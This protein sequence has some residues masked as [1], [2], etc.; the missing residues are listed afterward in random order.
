MF[1]ITYNCEPTLTDHQVIEFCQKGFIILEGVVADE[2]NRR[3]TNFLNDYPQLEPV[4]I[5]QEDWFV[6]SVIKNPQ[7]TGAVGSLL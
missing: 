4:E 6:E 3:T 5:L 7:A 2:I 1:D